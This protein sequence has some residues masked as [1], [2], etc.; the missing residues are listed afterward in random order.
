LCA[1]FVSAIVKPTVRQTV[2]LIRPTVQTPLGGGLA[3]TRAISSCLLSVVVG[4]SFGCAAPAVEIE[5]CIAKCGTCPSDMECRE[6]RCVRPDFQ[7]SC[8]ARGGASSGGGA[9]TAG[10]IGTAGA[11][12][13]GGGGNNADLGGAA[14]LGSVAGSGNAAGGSVAGSGNAAGGAAGSSNPAGLGNAAGTAGIAGISSVAGSGSSAGAADTGGLSNVSAM[15]GTVGNGGSTG[16]FEGGSIGTAGSGGAIGGTASSS[17]GTGGITAT[18][19]A[20][21]GISGGGAQVGSSAGIAGQW[22]GAGASQGGTG[23]C[24][25]AGPTAP[26]TITSRTLDMGCLGQD[27]G[28]DLIATG[29]NAADFEWS[30]VLPD[31]LGLTLTGSR[32]SGVLAKTG[33]YPFDVTVRDK[34]TTCSST[35]RV[36]LTVN[37]EAVTACPTIGIDGKGS[38]AALAPPSCRAWPYST[39]F[40][41]TGG[42]AP[43]SWQA[44]ELPPGSDLVFN[45]NTLEVTGTPTASGTVTVQV[46]DATGRSV[47]KSYSVPMRE[48]C[49]FAY[50]S[51]ETGRKRLELFDP[52]LG[53]RLTRPTTT[54]A[55]SVEDFAFS[56]DGKFIAYRVK[57]A[58]STQKLVLWQGPKW[59]RELELTLGGSVTHYAW[60]DNALVLA[61]A[62]S[63]A[64]DTMLGGV[65]VASVPENPPVAGIQGLTTLTAVSAPVDSELTWYGSDGYVAFHSPDDP[66]YPERV[67]D[68]VRYG[69]SGFA[70]LYRGTNWYDPSLMLY[71][72]AT[73][74]FAI[75]TIAPYPDFYGIGR[76]DWA[77][78]GNTA[79]APSGSFTASASGGQ[80]T[81]FHALDTSRLP[82]I[83]PW[84]VSGGCTSLLTWSARQE[85]LA[86]I[87]TTGD[88]TIRIQTLDIP[89]ATMQTAVLAGSQSYVNG[90]WSGHKRLMSPTGAWL[91]LTTNDRIY[92]GA[93]GQA[94]WTMPWNGQLS[95]SPTSTEMSYS[96]DERYLAVQNG[97]ALMLF[98]IA[99]SGG[100]WI[101]MGNLGVIAESCQEEWLAIPSWC[102][103]ANKT[104]GAVWS[105]DSQLIAYTTAAEILQIRDLRVA[106]VAAYIDTI[107]VVDVCADGCVGGFR[108]QP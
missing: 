97:T 81:L 54:A 55:V 23:G 95:A 79:I 33:D 31:G 71:P 49:W 19:G 57:D 98:D 76:S 107:R 2:P 104:T 56:P 96:P 38:S 66:D 84:V 34:T 22:E 82:G 29:G 91:A 36:M 13:I 50:I 94:S 21:G 17:A 48:K 102:G 43:Y 68:Y 52:F 99:T 108:F 105:P 64:T 14:G 40:K 9:G 73:G 72:S 30:A 42:T 93:L 61:V 16:G 85:R 78:H 8:S 6:H 80:L 89:N 77:R 44:F 25:G 62:F 65:G 58:T 69:A 75:E 28:V 12:A 67:V 60:S 35:A 53:K 26:P 86:C 24:A 74:F 37:G 5:D 88:P 4:L 106:Q 92:M 70:D 15:A 20:N 59:D 10:Q 1:T 11:G 45:P 41:V 7:G 87:D 51:K 32:I 100:N 90:T 27:Y 18:G 39:K 103:S 46:T 63:T 47:R 101:D 83:T 3:G